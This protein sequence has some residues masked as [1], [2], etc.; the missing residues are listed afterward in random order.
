LYKPPHVSNEIAE[1][2]V[3]LLQSETGAAY[4]HRLIT[5]YGIY[6]V[7]DLGAAV[8]HPNEPYQT[9]FLHPKAYKVIDVF[10]NYLVKEKAG[11]AERYIPD[12]NLVVAKIYGT[13]IKLYKSPDDSYIRRVEYPN[14]T[15]AFAITPTLFIWTYPKYEQQWKQFLSTKYAKWFLDLFKTVELPNLEKHFAYPVFYTPPAIQEVG[16][17]LYKVSAGNCSMIVQLH[18]N[19]PVP[20]KLIC[21]DKVCP[22]VVHNSLVCGKYASLWLNPITK[23]KIRQLAAQIH[24]DLDPEELLY[25][26]MQPQKTE[27]RFLSSKLKEEVLVPTI[28]PFDKAQVLETQLET[29]KLQ[30]LGLSISLKFVRAKLRLLYNNGSTKDISIR[31][32]LG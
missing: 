28:P 17:G 6:T 31:V 7:I 29:S 9:V 10:P 21:T 25:Q 4:L 22:G 32:L 12:K 19:K 13:N 8:I 20:Q 23:Q 1:S 27:V 16:S 11:I 2:I 15:I 5:T 18:D 24:P 3:G 14:N 30:Q 26:I